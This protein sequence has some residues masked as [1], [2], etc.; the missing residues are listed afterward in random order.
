M[1]SVCMNA[2]VAANYSSIFKRFPVIGDEARKIYDVLR[3]Q[4]SGAHFEAGFLPYAFSCHQLIEKSAQLRKAHTDLDAALQDISQRVRATYAKMAPS[5]LLRAVKEGD[6]RTAAQILE[7]NPKAKLRLSNGEMPLHYAIRYGST[8]IVNYLLQTAGIDPL[9]KDHQGLTAFDHAFLKKDPRMIALVMGAALGTSISESA[10]LSESAD[11]TEIQELGLD[12]RKF[13]YPPVAKLLPLHAAA[14][15]G[16]VSGLERLSKQ[17]ELFTADANGMTTL[18]YAVMGGNVAAVQWLLS[19]KGAK[20]ESADPNGINLLHLAAISGS[21]EVIRLLLDTKKF[22]PNTPDRNGRTSLHFAIAAEQLPAARALIKRGSD[23]LVRT[24][25]VTTPFA[26]L[27]TV[28][29]HRAALRD[30]LKLDLG[31]LLT[32]GLFAASAACNYAGFSGANQFFSALPVLGMVRQLP[33]FGHPI[34]EISKGAIFGHSLTAH[35]TDHQLHKSCYQG[36]HT[37]TLGKQFFDG[38]RISWK[39]S[40]LETY[41]PLRNMW[42]HGANTLFSAWQLFETSGLKKQIVCE[43]GSAAQCILQNDL[44]PEY[45]QPKGCGEFEIGKTAADLE[46]SCDPATREASFQKCLAGREKTE[47]CEMLYPIEDSATCKARLK[48][49]WDASLQYCRQGGE[50][51][52]G[53][54]ETIMRKGGFGQTDL[55]TAKKNLFS[56]FEEETIRGKD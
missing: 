25:L 41:R 32:L 39:N 44:L 9:S 42:I 4:E 30:P 24:T 29:K 50:R 26:I 48:P 43:W 53:D 33:H 45:I 11:Q 23:P 51:S 17:T 13:R 27:N 19:K 22:N 56:K 54:A 37:V 6:V 3:A 46:W 5:D 10:L 14:F 7:M 12:I 16:D 2:V 1:I 35:F 15:L 8:D 18:S 34:L 49:I 20:L 31:T 47:D 28:S 21:E 40:G 52:L 55:E 38:C 36:L